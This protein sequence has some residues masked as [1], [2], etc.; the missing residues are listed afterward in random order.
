MAKK[1][2]GRQFVFAISKNGRCDDESIPDDAGDWMT[3]CVNLRADVFDYNAST[4][5]DGS[6]GGGQ[7]HAVPQKKAPLPRI[8]PQER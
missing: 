8:R 6:I 4:S 1:Q 7:W 2:P 5:I 3:A